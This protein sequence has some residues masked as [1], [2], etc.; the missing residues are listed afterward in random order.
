MMPSLREGLKFRDKWERSA[1]FGDDDKEDKTIRSEGGVDEGTDRTP[2][3]QTRSG[4]EVCS[5]EQI[6]EGRIGWIP[7]KTN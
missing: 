4:K 6:A 7:R 1:Q 2:G 5:K 3:G